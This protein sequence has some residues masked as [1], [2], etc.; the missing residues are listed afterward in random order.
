M[1]VINSKGNCVLMNVP[2]NV[3]CHT[4]ILNLVHLF[5]V[6]LHDLIQCLVCGFCGVLSSFTIAAYGYKAKP[7]SNTVIHGDCVEQVMPHLEEIQS[8]FKGNTINFHKS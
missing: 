7:R 5:T 3:N 2:Q 4:E 6:K 8:W 1:F